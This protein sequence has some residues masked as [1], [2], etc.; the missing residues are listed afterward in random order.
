M[1]TRSNN[2]HQDVISVSRNKKRLPVRHAFSQPLRFMP[3]YYVLFTIYCALNLLKFTSF[4]ELSWM[5]IGQLYLLIRIVSTLV[6]GVRI[7]VQRFQ[8][9]QYAL[10]LVVGSCVLASTFISGSWNILLLLLFLIAGREVNLRKI[11]IC[12]LCTN[13]AVIF[14]TVICA[15]NGIIKKN[16]IYC[17][18]W[19]AGAASFW[20]YSS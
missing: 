3:I 2:I 9:K 10:C 11:A 17:G 19:N 4:Q 12:V 14:L 6:L 16:N 15:N 20:L 13:V 7:L 18:E 8:A 1:S 5:N